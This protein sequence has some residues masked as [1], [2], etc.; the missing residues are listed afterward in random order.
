MFFAGFLIGFGCLSFILG[1]FFLVVHIAD[2]SKSLPVLAIFDQANAY[3]DITLL[4]GGILAGLGVLMMLLGIILS[5]SKR[6]KKAAPAPQEF[7]P[8]PQYQPQPFRTPEPPRYQAPQQPQYQQPAPQQPA[9]EAPA[10][11]QPAFE[12]PAPQQ[13]AFEEPKP[14]EP[15]T[16]APA[17]EEPAPQAVAFCFNCGAKLT[18]GA[19]FCPNCGNK[20]Q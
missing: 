8:Q 10:P 1:A 20:I 5:L 12:A 9:F 3:L 4:V 7:R 14:E 11:Q 19:A 15:V 13:P 2:L 6:Q 17:A 18:P 16:A